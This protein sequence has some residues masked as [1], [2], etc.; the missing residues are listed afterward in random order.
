VSQSFPPQ[1]DQSKL[2]SQCAVSEKDAF[3]SADKSE[4]VSQSQGMDVPLSEFEVAFLQKFRP[5]TQ[6]TPKKAVSSRAL[7]NHLVNGEQAYIERT[8]A[9]NGVILNDDSR[10]QLLNKYQRLCNVAIKTLGERGI[11]AEGETP[12]LIELVGRSMDGLPGNE[13]GE[14]DLMRDRALQAL[15]SIGVH[16]PEIARALITYKLESISL[17]MEIKA[18]LEKSSFS[19]RSLIDEVLSVHLFS[20][21]GDV[22]NRALTFISIHG[23]TSKATGPAVIRSFEEHEVSDPL[24]KWKYEYR[25]VFI[26]NIGTSPEIAA[27][28][29]KLITSDN[30]KEFEF[31]M[32]VIFNAGEAGAELM[33]GENGLSDEQLLTV[34]PKYRA[35][36]AERRAEIEAHFAKRLR[37]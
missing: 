25:Q 21:E 10:E 26:N 6:E 5:P 34:G 23:N 35:A 17:E 36:K 33:Y 29:I 15:I 20:E 13:F 14:L 11:A 7:V 2:T 32:D 4:I 12:R 3:G 18:A 22:S 28:V 31:G 30:L 19:A 9:K 27:Y 16:T 24:R 1:S 8:I 37:N